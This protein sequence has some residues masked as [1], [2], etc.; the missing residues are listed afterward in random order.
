VQSGRRAC[1]A[2]PLDG[3]PL[4]ERDREGYKLYLEAMKGGGTADR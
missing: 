3:I 2:G 4:T 1:A